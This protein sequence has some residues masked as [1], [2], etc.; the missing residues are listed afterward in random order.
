MDA[1]EQKLARDKE[2]AKK[3]A[4]WGNFHKEKT[5]PYPKQFATY[6]TSYNLLELHINL[7][8]D[9]FAL[10]Y[11]VGGVATSNPLVTYD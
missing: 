2:F 6:L 11:Y 10:M 1:K 4:A 8:K 3:F 5:N 7:K 9:V